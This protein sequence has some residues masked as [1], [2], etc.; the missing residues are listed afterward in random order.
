MFPWVAKKLQ[1]RTFVQV[2]NNLAEVLTLYF[3]NLFIHAIFYSVYF[4]VLH[5]LLNVSL[6]PYLQA[7]LELSS[8]RLDVLK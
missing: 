8:E 2:G 7:N 5:C 3:F 4:Q 6:I 1:L